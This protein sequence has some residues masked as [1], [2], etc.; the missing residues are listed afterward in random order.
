MEKDLRLSHFNY[1]L[2]DNSNKTHLD[3]FDELWLDE[4]TNK[5]LYN[6][7]DFINNIIKGTNEYDCIYL[8]KIK[9]KIIGFVS[10][11]YSDNTYEI[12]DGI[13]PRYRGNSYSAILLNEFSSYIFSNTNIDTL[14]G[15]IEKNNNSSIKSALKNGFVQTNEKEYIIKK[16]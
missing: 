11:Y 3:F 12:S 9:E 7:E 5:Y 1:E 10:I 4:E 13:L 2:Y 6:K 15:Y 16:R 8:V 14:Y